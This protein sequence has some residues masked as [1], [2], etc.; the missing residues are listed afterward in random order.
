MY[1]FSRPNWGDKIPI[2]SDASR[3]THKALFFFPDQ[4]R[5]INHL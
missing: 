3:I 2:E 1:F 5:V 4:V